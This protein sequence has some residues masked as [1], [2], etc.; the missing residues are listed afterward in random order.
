MGK[1]CELAPRGP[2][3][4]AKCPATQCAWDCVE[5]KCVQKSDFPTECM[6]MGMGGMGMGGMGMGMG[7]NGMTSGAHPIYGNQGYGNTGYGQGGMSMSRNYAGPAPKQFGGFGQ[8]NMGG[9]Y[10][11]MHGGMG[12]GYGGMNQM[13]NGMGGGYGMNQMHG[14]MGGGYGM[15]QMHGGYGGGYHHLTSKRNTDLNKE[16]KKEEKI[17]NIIQKQKEPSQKH[18]TIPILK[19][20]PAST[21]ISNQTRRV[22][23]V[24]PPRGSKY[25]PGQ[26][27]SGGAGRSYPSSKYGTYPNSG[28]G[29]GGGMYPNSYPGSSTYGTGSYGAGGYPGSYGRQGYGTHGYYGYRK[30]RYNS[31]TTVTY[32]LLAITPF[33]LICSFCAGRYYGTK[34]NVEQQ[35]QYPIQFDRFDRSDPVVSQYAEFDRETAN[36]A[37]SK[38]KI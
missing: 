29:T 32:A 13:H 10:G 26:Y 16:I 24:Q 7:M 15:N 5:H 27:P 1:V 36:R 21:I 9:G 17:T 14:G 3:A 31:S 35:Q 4:Q 8:T 6:G 37:R 18:Q 28:Y 19:K 30:K 20:P 38:S 34:S 2:Q 22:L 33:I 12:G 11:G 25:P 23:Q